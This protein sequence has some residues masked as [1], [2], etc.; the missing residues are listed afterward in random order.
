MPLKKKQHEVISPEFYRGLER[1]LVGNAFQVR[2]AVDPR[3][4]ILPPAACG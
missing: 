4:A 3:S 2:E 1:L